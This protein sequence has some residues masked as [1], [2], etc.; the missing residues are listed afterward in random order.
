MKTL[1]TISMFLLLGAANLTSPEVYISNSGTATKY[2][3]KHDC[4][5]LNA[6][7][8]EVVKLV[9]EKAVEQGYG[10]CGWED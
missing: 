2:H 3:L 7:K 8:A 10:L 5:G 4:R 9:K 6:C 1:L